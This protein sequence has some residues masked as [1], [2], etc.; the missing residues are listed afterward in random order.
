MSQSTDEIRQIQMMMTLML[1]AK[2]DGKLREVFERAL[3][4]AGSQAE[5][6]L[7]ACSDT[8]ADGLKGWL[9]SVLAQGGLTA[10][11]QALVEWQNDPEN[12]KAAIDELKA[13]EDAANIKFAIQ[14]KS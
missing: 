5:T 3:T 4:A 10:E 12:M 6:K 1:L 14:T 8:S 9:E 13:L 11:E 7:T 2:P